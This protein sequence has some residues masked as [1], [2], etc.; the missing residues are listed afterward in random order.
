MKIHAPINQ[1]GLIGQIGFD[2]E[3]HDGF[4]DVF[5]L[6]QPTNRIHIYNYPVI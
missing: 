6:A 4:N 2:Q 3:H 5:R 1:E